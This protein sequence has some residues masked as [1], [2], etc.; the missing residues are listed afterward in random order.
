MKG[1]KFADNDE[2]NCMAYDWLEG[3]STNVI[4]T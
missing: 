2:E 1:C 4:W 3:P